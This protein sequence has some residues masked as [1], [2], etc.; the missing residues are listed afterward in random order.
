[1]ARTI[2]RMAI[3]ATITHR[4]CTTVCGMASPIAAS[5]HSTRNTHSTSRHSE[6]SNL[7]T[8]ST[9]TAER[10]QGSF[11]PLGTVRT[12]EDLQAVLRS[13]A[14]RRQISRE[15]IDELAGLTKGYTGKLLAEVPT[16]KLG[17]EGIGALLGALG[18]K[19]IAVDDPVALERFTKRAAKRN[20]SQTRMHAGTVHIKISGRKFRQNQKKGGVNSR[21]YLSR[22]KARKLARKAAMARWHKPAAVDAQ[23][24]A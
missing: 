14:E 15:A 1:M 6:I 22:R 21:K 20:G 3:S 9:M 8:D 10:G 12:Y 19:L 7:M 5:T 16:K 4:I 24:P 11:V 18:V 2:S 13:V 17:I 23:M